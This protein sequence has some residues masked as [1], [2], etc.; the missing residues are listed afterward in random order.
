[1]NKQSCWVTE[2]FGDVAKA[3]TDRQ[4]DIMSKSGIQ[5]ITLGALDSVTSAQAEIVVKAGNL[6]CSGPIVDP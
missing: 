5:S 6:V 3:S 1:M 2:I 4:F